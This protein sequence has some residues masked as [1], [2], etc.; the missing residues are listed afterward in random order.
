[1][2]TD[3]DMNVN[4]HQ[5][6]CKDFAI[7]PDVS[8]GNDKELMYLTLGL[9]G[10]AGEVAEKI[11]KAYRD[12]E[13]DPEQIAYECGDVYWYL[14]QLLERLGYTPGLVLAMNYNKLASRKKRGKLSGS[15]DGR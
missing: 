11:K 5:K 2:K 6:W 3:K 13:F 10:E 4:D 7:Y 1:M 8:T 9:V 14:G 12:K 15:G